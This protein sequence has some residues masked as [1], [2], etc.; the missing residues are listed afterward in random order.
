[1]ELILGAI[2]AVIIINAYIL[3]YAGLI[4]WVFGEVAFLASLAWEITVTTASAIRRL[5]ALID[6]TS[7]R[8]LQLRPTAQVH[9]V[10]CPSGVV[11]ECGIKLQ[12]DGSFVLPDGFVCDPES[13]LRRCRIG[14]A[15]L[16]RAAGPCKPLIIHRP[17][18]P[19]IHIQWTGTE[20]L[21]SDR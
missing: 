10:P 17:H 11:L 21:R 1:M 5:V 16:S 6:S 18:L 15:L 19:T 2:F 12:P 13:T 3:T 9:W 7:F 20:W 14:H 8:L 4:K